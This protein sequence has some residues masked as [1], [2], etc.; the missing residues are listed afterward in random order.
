[1]AEESPRRALVV[2][3]HPDDAEVGCGGTVAQWSQEGWEFFYLVTTNGAKGTDDPRL[4]PQELVAMREVEQRAAAAKLGA[5]DVFFL[6]YE[7]GELTYSRELLGRVTRVIR[8]VRPT[9]LFTHDPEVLIHVWNREEHR[10][11][12]QH[13]DHRCTGLVSL[14]AVYPTARDRLNFPEHIHEGLEP[15]KVEELYFWGSNQPDFEVDITDVQELKIEALLCHASQF[16]EGK[17]MFERWRDR[18]RSEDGRY[19]ERFRKIVLGF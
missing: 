17:A 5:K 7:D 19:R 11:A 13:S 3:A 1:M 9:A 2:A 16:P 4:A 10:G 6:G 8:E 12:V 18:W 14:D 15:H